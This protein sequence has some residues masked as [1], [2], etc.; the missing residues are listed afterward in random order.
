MYRYFNS[1]FWFNIWQKL[2]FQQISMNL[3]KHI[4]NLPVKIHTGKCMRLTE[5]HD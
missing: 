5:V 2:M 4:F 3:I 1:L